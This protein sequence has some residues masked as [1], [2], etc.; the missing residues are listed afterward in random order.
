MVATGL[1]DNE[2][3]ASICVPL[4]FPTQ[5]LRALSIQALQHLVYEH[6]QSYFFSYQ[7]VVFSSGG[8]S[9]ELIVSVFFLETII[10]VF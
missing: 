7:V 6:S 1:R 4:Q 9:C 5:A 8:Y 2:G 10:A 3:G